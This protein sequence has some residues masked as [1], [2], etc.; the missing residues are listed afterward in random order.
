MYGLKHFPEWCRPGFHWYPT[1]FRKKRG[2]GWGTEV[3]SKSEI[4]LKPVPFSICP[5]FKCD[6]PA[7]FAIKLRNGWGT[8]LLFEGRINKVVP[9]QNPTFTTGCQVWAA[10]VWV[11]SK[12]AVEKRGGWGGSQAPV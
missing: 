12:E 9:F 7:H 11:N 6:C 2:N 8:V 10:R 5:F 3:Y 4:A 1:H